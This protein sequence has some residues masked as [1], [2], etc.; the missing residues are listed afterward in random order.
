MNS[1]FQTTL[2]NEDALEHSFTFGAQEEQQPCSTQCSTHE[3]FTIWCNGSIGQ[4]IVNSDGM[5]IAW[6]TNP[7]VA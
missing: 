1:S 4:E 2:S 5:T 3:Q 7:W 6:T